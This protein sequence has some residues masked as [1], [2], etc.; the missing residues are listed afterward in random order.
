MGYQLLSSLLHKRYR[1]TVQE[2][3]SSNRREMSNDERL[4]G[5]QE[6]MM[7]I[8]DF[9]YDS[10]V[11]RINNDSELIRLYYAA[12]NNYEKL[13]LYRMIFDD[14]DQ[15]VDSDIIAK[16]INQAFHMENDFIYQLDPRKYQ[17][18]PQYVISECNR[19]VESIND[20]TKLGGIG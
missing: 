10:I 20:G 1:P 15:N 8:P 9:N 14:K 17:M 18:V 12:D 7:L 3:N 11:T 19:L 16:F 13:H 5:E 6:I 4:K 2:R